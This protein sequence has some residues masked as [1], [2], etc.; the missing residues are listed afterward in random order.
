MAEKIPKWADRVWNPIDWADMKSGR[1]LKFFPDRLEQPLRTKKAYLYAVSPYVNVFH[2]KITDKQINKILDVIYRTP[3]HVFVFHDIDIS[4]FSAYSMNT[5]LSC[6]IEINKLIPN[7]YWL[8]PLIDEKE[9]PPIYVDGKYF[10]EKNKVNIEIKN[11]FDRLLGTSDKNFLQSGK[12]MDLYKWDFIKATLRE[13]NPDWMPQDRKQRI[14]Y[15]FGCLKKGAEK[16]SGNPYNNRSLFTLLN[17]SKMPV[18]NFKVSD[19]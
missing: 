16:W 18:L 19:E 14:I 7:I 1:K 2:D 12:A 13:L 5:Y 6:G 8:D 10:E 3:W 9:V 11:L 17:K 4:R 15:I